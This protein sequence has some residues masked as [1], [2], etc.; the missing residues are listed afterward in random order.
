MKKIN[1][2]LLILFISL[3][4]YSCNKNTEKKY[5]TVTLNLMEGNLINEDQE[6]TF[7]VLEGTTISLPTVEKNGY[8]FNGW[9]TKLQET[10]KSDFSS[11]TPVT[12][13]LVVYA[14][15]RP[16]HLS[17]NANG[18]I[19][20][21]YNTIDEAIKGFM[22]DFALYTNRY[23]TATS[24]FDMSYR[25]LRSFLTDHPEWISFI[26]YLE[27]NASSQTKPYFATLMT[28]D[29]N[30]GNSDSY[31][32]AEI[33]AFLNKSY[34]K[35][36]N[37]NPDFKPSTCNYSNTTLLEQVWPYLPSYNPTFYTSSENFTLPIPHKEGYIFE[38]WCENEDLS[39]TPVFEILQG[40]S[41][42]KIYYAKWNIQ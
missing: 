32:R 35:G 41:T 10:M 2:F 18:G 11:Q 36:S 13:N 30:N 40:S 22:N 14:L 1:L 17:L 31:V 20:T 25:K 19:I 34:F 4:F 24:F 9:S 27:K 3:G 38:G 16:P 7:N 42:D 21:K 8:I 39:D 29:I 15:W 28:E 5:Y 33:S 37:Y 26:D 12:S 23:I 6:T